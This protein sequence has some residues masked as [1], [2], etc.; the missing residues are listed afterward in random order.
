M[1][2]TQSFFRRKVVIVDDINL[3]KICQIVLIPK[4]E[5]NIQIRLPEIKSDFTI[6]ATKLLKKK[7]ENISEYAIPRILF[8]LTSYKQMI[9]GTAIYNDTSF[10]LNIEN[11]PSKSWIELII[12][13]PNQ[14]PSTKFNFKKI[15]V[16]FKLND[17]RRQIYKYI[18]SFTDTQ[19]II[20]LLKSNTKTVDPNVSVIVKIRTDVVVESHLKTK[21]GEFM[22]FLHCQTYQSRPTINS[23]LLLRLS[24]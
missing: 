14:M 15:G 18:L 3:Y 24:I 2:Y 8:K 1:I 19:Q 5:M 12:R 16:D 9:S 7:L 23:P 4:F 17:D 6:V 13:G 10:M 20:F 21:K 22:N 11:F